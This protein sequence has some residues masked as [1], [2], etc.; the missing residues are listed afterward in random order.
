MPGLIDAAYTLHILQQLPITAVDLAPPSQRRVNVLELQHAQ[1]G[2][3]FAH[4]S[5]DPRCH[6]C[7]FVHEAEILQMI[8]MLLDLGIRADDS[9]AF[10]GSEYLS[11][12]KAQYR[13]VAMLQHAAAM[14]LYAEGM[15]GIVNDLEVIVIGDNL[16]G[17]YIAGVAVAMHRQNGRGLR[18][19][20]GLDFGGIEIQRIRIDIDEYRLDAVPQQG[21]RGSDERIRGGDD[22][23][24]NTQRLQSGHQRESAI[25]EQRQMI[26]AQIVTQRLL[27]LLMKRSFVS[28]D[29][30]IPYLLQ[31]GDELLQWRQV[32]LS[33]VDRLVAHCPCFPKFSDSP[34]QP[35]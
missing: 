18:G 33:N 13:Q 5:V 32:G 19:D 28:E 25:S 11:G 2:V 9:A 17:L 20:G 34:E 26:D 21:M 31:I 8:D 27:E 3:E 35:A 23:A 6:H 1:S 24:G 10:K 14:A 30:T 15:G 4:F 7:R 12:V 29:L 22:F 16:D